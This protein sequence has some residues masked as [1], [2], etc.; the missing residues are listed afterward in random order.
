MKAKLQF[1]TSLF[2]AAMLF[3]VLMMGQQERNSVLSYDLAQMSEQERHDFLQARK[4]AIANQ[5][6]FPIQ[7]RDW[8]PGNAYFYSAFGTDTDNF[9]YFPLEGPFTPYTG[10]GVFDRSFFADDFDYNGNLYGLE[11]GTNI[12]SQVDVDTGEVTDLLTVGVVGDEYT[13]TGLS[14]NPVNGLMYGLAAETATSSSR[15]FSINLDSGEVQLLAGAIPD[16]IGIWLAIDN[17]GTAYVAALDDQLYSIDLTDGTPT[18]IGALGIDINFAQE[19]DIDPE[20]GNLY[21][22][23]Y[24]IDE[25]NPIGVYLVD[26]ATGAATLQYETGDNEITMFSV[27]NAYPE[28]VCTPPTVSF[29]YTDDCDTLTYTMVANVT[30]LGSDGSFVLSYG[31]MSMTID[32]T[33]MYDMGSFDSGTSLTVN[34][35]TSND[36]CSSVI[37]TSHE[38]DCLIYDV[39]VEVDCETGLMDQSYCYGEN[40]QQNWLFTSS[41]GQPLTITFTAGLIESYS[42][43]NIFFYDGVDNTGTLLYDTDDG[44]GSDDL[45]GLSLTADS[46]SLYIYYYSDSSVSCE[47][48]SSGYVPWEYNVV[49]EGMATNDINGLDDIVI[50]PNPVKDTFFIGGLDR[51]LGNY[52]VNIYTTTGKLV[53]QSALSVQDGVNV[54][55]LKAGVYM[56]EISQNGKVVKQA[57]VMKK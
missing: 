20:T 15:L 49:C 1:L 17:D 12:L 13:V 44:S 51:T 53:S 4:I 48:G 38:V 50:Y 54:S 14:Y 23:A 52:Q 29:E 10:L 16:T 40:Q 42:F 24:I 36:S 56:V 27:S 22:A 33:G 45:T 11:Y 31:S 7:Q 34:I 2:L 41:T 21:M 57:K 6:N 18:L 39:N 28:V 37:S 30:D 43:D 35:T 3:P 46:G 5:D 8:I 55:P 47:Y 19:A 26:K 9:G 32:E 25:V